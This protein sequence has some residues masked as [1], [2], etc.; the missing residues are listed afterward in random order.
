[1]K[2][3]DGE[4]TRVFDKNS[5]IKLIQENRK[6]YEEDQK[7]LMN[8]EQAKKNKLREVAM[9]NI[10]L[11]KNKVDHLMLIKDLD[12]KEEANYLQNGLKL[13]DVNQERFRDVVKRLDM[14]N[15]R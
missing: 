7:Y 10:H 4:W 5:Q 8:Q 12:R 1:M 14:K 3:K 9:Q 2:R 13:L 11:A 15:N 6:K